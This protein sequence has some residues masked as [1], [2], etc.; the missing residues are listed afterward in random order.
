MN[1]RNYLGRFVRKFETEIEQ[2]GDHRIIFFVRGL[3]VAE[4]IDLCEQGFIEKAKPS[5]SQFIAIGISTIVGWEGIEEKATKERIRNHIPDD[6]LIE[7]GKFAYK[8]LTMLS[9]DE[10]EKLKGHVNFLH[11]ASKDENEAKAKNFNC[12]NCL[13]KNIAKKRPCGRFTDEEIEV[14][15]KRLNDKIDDDEE[16]D[17]QDTGD[18]LNKYSRDKKFQTKK[19]AED[20]KERNAI[21]GGDVIRVGDYT[22]PECPVSW[23]DD[24]LEEL[25]DALFHCHSKDLSFFGDAVADEPYKFYKAQK[26][27]SGT[28]SKLRSEEMEEDRESS[29]SKKPRTHT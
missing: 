14:H 23:V 11:W 8:E 2:W 25:G 9:E 29:K 27:V 22:F 24:Y 6:V 3:T 1:E 18:L 28:V 17:G 15:H 21:T 20:Y 13:K 4:F 5:F 12:Q 16:E 19:S 26:V 10:Y 7:V